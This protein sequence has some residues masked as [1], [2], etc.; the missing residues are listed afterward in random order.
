MTLQQMRDFLAIVEQGSMHGA[1]RF[2]GQTQPAL[3]RSLRRLELS[4]GAPLLDR[5]ARG[6]ELNDF[7]RTFAAHVRRLMA[8]VQ[9]TRDAMQEALG[10]RGGRVAFGIS[11]AASIV[12]APQAV[13][14]FRREFPDTELRSRAGL[15]HTLV[16]LLRD[17]QLDFFISPLPAGP[18]DPQLN[19][20]TLID[21]QMVLV[22]RRDHPKARA[23]RLQTLSQERFVI[24]G[25]RGQPGAGIFDVF[26]AAGLP[27]PQIE[28]QTDGLLDS[29]A[30]VAGSDCLALLPAALM[31]SGLLRERLVVLP[32][33]EGLPA[34][35]VALFERAHVPPTA[36][37]AALAV[38]FERESAYLRKPA[39]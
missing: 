18:V 4:L 16:P 28:V 13:R 8:D 36:A 23:R 19:S 20:R 22:A 17:G 12:L 27:P 10:Q 31:H 3:T 7:G 29:A 6:V 2:T 39:A 35:Q 33:T 1:A 34:Y 26:E 37:A 30:M 32:I 25:P 15:Y 24:G 11:A 38:Q 9:R 5:H 21:S 14:R